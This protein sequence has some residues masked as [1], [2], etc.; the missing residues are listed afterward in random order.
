M[1]ENLAR[2]SNTYSM[3]ARMK[4]KEEDMRRNL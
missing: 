1:N 3:F 2:H 4:E